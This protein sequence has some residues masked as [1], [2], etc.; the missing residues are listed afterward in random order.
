MISG[1][2]KFTVQLPTAGELHEWII[3]HENKFAVSTVGALL[4]RLGWLG[5][6][7]K[8]LVKVN[9]RA[10]FVFWMEHQLPVWNF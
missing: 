6:M 2:A 8:R 4:S 7:G 3:V 10:V 1:G 9:W 5:E